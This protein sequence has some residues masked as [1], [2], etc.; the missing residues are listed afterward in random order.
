MAKKHDS[1]WSTYLVFKLLTEML[2][3]DRIP[4]TPIKNKE[5]SLDVHT[6]ELVL[7]VATSVV[8]TAPEIPRMKALVALEMKQ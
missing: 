7:V 3:A 1:N 2:L 4:V 5:G 6:E 8:R